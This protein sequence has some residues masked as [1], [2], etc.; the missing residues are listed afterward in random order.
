MAT[1][2]DF[3]YDLMVSPS[4]SLQLRFIDAL[5]LLRNPNK[6]G[7]VLQN[8]DSGNGLGIDIKNFG[9]VA[10]TADQI[11]WAY[12]ALL[13]IGEYQNLLIDSARTSKGSAEDLFKASARNGFAELAA[14]LPG[15]TTWRGLIDLVAT[16]SP[17]LQDW[18][19]AG[20]RVMQD[21]LGKSLNLSSNVDVDVEGDFKSNVLLAFPENTLSPSFEFMRRR[22][23]DTSCGPS[24]AEILIS[25]SPSKK[26]VMLCKTPFCATLSGQASFTLLG[27]NSAI[28]GSDNVGERAVLSV[29]QSA[30]IDAEIEISES[31]KEFAK[32]VIAPSRAQREAVFAAAT[33]SALEII[34]NNDFSEKSASEILQVMDASAD[35]LLNDPNSPYS[36]KGYTRKDVHAIMLESMFGS[37][38]VSEIALKIQE[39]LTSCIQQVNSINAVLAATDSDLLKGDFTESLRLAREQVVEDYDSLLNYASILFDIQSPSSDELRANGEPVSLATVAIYSVAVTAA[40]A[41]MYGI[42]KIIDVRKKQTC[43]DLLG[44][45]KSAHESAK[46]MVQSVLQTA[47]NVNELDALIRILND[48]QIKIE[49][50][51]RVL[52]NN[53]CTAAFVKGFD[54]LKPALQSIEAKPTFDEKKAVLN[55]IAQC[56][57]A[58]GVRIENDKKVVDEQIAKLEKENPL[59]AWMNF[60]STLFNQSASVLTYALYGA[61]GLGA[62]WGGIKVYKAFK[63]NDN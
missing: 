31:G 61:L 50:N 52:A 13:V 25:R 21:T 55:V 41:V 5:S 27:F 15:N 36:G 47:V 57:G 3:T 35:V 49:T 60:V 39:G 56:L 40:V 26:M 42:F 16:R 9:K 7:S 10:L 43:S 58:E 34:N 62:L 19:D 33:K 24:K 54:C 48:G 14:V 2:N 23:V 44:V 38:G 59:T 30:L 46:T 22:F 11:L 8:I 63:S 4:T 12:T 45:E 20:T 29:T 18:S 53:E 32:N 17:R 51:A 37:G 28:V 1:I 6:L